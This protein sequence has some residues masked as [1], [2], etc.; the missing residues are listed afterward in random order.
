MDEGVRNS[1][2]MEAL[3]GTRFGGLGNW[4]VEETTSC[5]TSKEGFM[6]I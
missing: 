6:S 3:M 4:E 5:T 2:E 1:A